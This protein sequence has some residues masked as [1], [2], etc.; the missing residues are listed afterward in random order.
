MN[1]TAYRFDP[2]LERASTLPS[3]CYLDSW[4]ETEEKRSI[5][6]RT[7]QLAGHS[8]AVIS[9]GDFFTTNV[10]G[11][12]V[13]V[14]RGRD[15]MLRALSNICR[16]RA[17]PVAKGSGN[18]P[19]FQ[20]GYHGWTYRLDGSLGGTPEMAGIECFE[21]SDFSLPSFR[22]EEWLGL[23]FVNLDPDAAPLLSQLQDLPERL[24]RRGLDSFRL[25]ER[26]DWTIECNWKV[27]VDNYLEGYHIPIVHPS[28]FQ[29]LD[30]SQYRTETRDIYSI[31]HAPL[32]RRE[33]LRSQSPD[34]RAEYFWIYPNL[35]LNVYPDNFSTNL[36]VPLSPTRTMTIFEWYF[37]DPEMARQDIGATIAY[38]DEIQIEDIDICETVQ[39]NLASATYSAGRFSPQR[40]N[41]VHHFHGLLAKSLGKVLTDPL[42]GIPGAANLT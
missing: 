32:K 9:P 39:R 15:G 14:V 10:A 6:A 19:V 7:W 36:I 11:E 37:A 21:A 8:A 41:G 17:G 1:R 12:P 16:H 33:R 22:V 25:A 18:R 29:E 42:D 34:D 13:I 38:S 30:Y 40:E 5:F 3:W 28:L 4:L 31:Q 20:C 23:V 2:R 26:K 35:M 27:Y 24:E